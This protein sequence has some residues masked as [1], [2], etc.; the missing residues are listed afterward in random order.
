MTLRARTNGT[1]PSV[2]HLVGAAQLRPARRG[3]RRAGRGGQRHEA[4][5]SRPAVL[6][7]LLAAAAPADAA[8]RLI[9]IETPAA[10]SPRRRAL[11]RR[12]PPPPPARERAAPRRIRRPAALPRPV[13]APWRRRPGRGLGP[14]RR[15]ATSRTPPA[16]CRAIVVMPEGAT[17][18]YTNWW[19]G[20]RRG[21]P[22]WERFFIDELVPLVER[23]F[24]VAPGP[25]QPRDRRAVDGRLRRHVH[26]VAAPRVLRLRVELLRAAPAPAA[27]G[28]ARARGLR[29]PLSGRVRPPGRR[30]TRPAT[31]RPAWPPTCAPPACT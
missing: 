22:G 4:R 3:D 5:R 7:L 23:R 29:R 6:A 2:A 19:N 24:R 27:P 18:F 16:A 26:R 12:R 31:T 1:D 30:S 13:P 25:A 11:Q 20:G 8:Q 28:R 21:A 14:R 10:T 15:T 9:T 17:G